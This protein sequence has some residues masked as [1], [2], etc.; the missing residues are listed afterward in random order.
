MDSF[1]RLTLKVSLYNDSTEK[2][3]HLLHVNGD[4][5]ARGRL[6]DVIEQ[7]VKRRS[8]RI[9]A[10]FFNK[11]RRISSK[12]YAYAITLSSQCGC[13]AVTGVILDCMQSHDGAAE[14]VAARTPFVD[15][16]ALD[17]DVLARIPN[18]QF[19]LPHAHNTT[20]VDWVVRSPCRDG[21]A[22]AQVVEKLYNT[23]DPERCAEP[24][25]SAMRGGWDSGVHDLMDHWHTRLGTVALRETAKEALRSAIFEDLRAG[26]AV[27][28]WF[29]EQREDAW[30]PDG[31]AACGLHAVLRDVA[32]DAVSHNSFALVKALLLTWIQHPGPVGVPHSEV[33][34]LKHIIQH[35]K[36]HADT[37]FRMC[38]D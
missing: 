7:L 23:G 8:A 33:I 16:S 5:I 2:C 29:L 12:I 19:T 13:P 21:M 10:A 24:I 18:P 6:M 37:V 17:P 30:D 27:V 38:D 1:T 9:A 28:S 20:M 34:S 25:V 26:A 15:A 4:T 11:T 14:R 22:L 36:T 35:S 31:E 32:L 3:Q